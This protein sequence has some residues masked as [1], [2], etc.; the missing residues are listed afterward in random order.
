MNI[1][2][3]IGE[4][5][6]MRQNDLLISKSYFEEAGEDWNYEEIDRAFDRLQ[7]SL[8]RLLIG[9]QY[10]TNPDC[11]CSAKSGVKGVVKA[12]K[13]IFKEN[14]YGSQYQYLIDDL[15]KELET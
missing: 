11:P 15:L 14:L 7:T 10:C 9:H 2:K 6:E 3:L 4:I 1:E 5:I 13:E 8:T 12:Y